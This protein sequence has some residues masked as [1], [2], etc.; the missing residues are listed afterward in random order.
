MV[1]SGP[2]MASAPPN[3]GPATFDALFGQCADDLH[4]YSCSLPAC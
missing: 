3:T 4:A 1:D 2:V